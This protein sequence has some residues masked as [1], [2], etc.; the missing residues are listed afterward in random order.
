MTDTTRRNAGLRQMLSVRRR[1]VE[2]DVQSRLRHGRADRSNDV[3][4]D[5]EHSDA[6][7]QH[8]LEFSVL[9]MRADTLAQIDEALRRLDAG[10]YGACRE[11]EREIAGGRLRALP[12]AA[13]VRSSS[14]EL[15]AA[16]VQSAVVTDSVSPL[17]ITRRTSRVG[18]DRGADSRAVPV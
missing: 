12:F 9:Q 14:T 7:V 18:I 2:D 3:G 6:D 4:D 16:A 11:C 1:A 10:K 5:L 15:S 17:L 13:I 8:G